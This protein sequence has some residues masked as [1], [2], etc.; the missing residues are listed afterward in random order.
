ML[1]QQ[2]H[3]E[4][5]AFLKADYHEFDEESKCFFDEGY[6]DYNDRVSDTETN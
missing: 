6:A 2:L 1:N 3:D 4:L 5:A